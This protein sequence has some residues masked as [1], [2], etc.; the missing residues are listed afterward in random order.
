[1]CGLEADARIIFKLDD[2]NG[3]KVKV[4]F[5]QASYEDGK[6]EIESEVGEEN[7]S[8]IEAAKSLYDYS[9][10]QSVLKGFEYLSDARVEMYSKHKADLQ[11]L[12][13]VYKANL[14]QEKYDVMFRSS[15]KGTYSAYCNSLNST[16]SLAEEKKYRRNMKERGR[17]E[18]Y[19]KIEKDLKEIKG[20]EVEYILKE[21]E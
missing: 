14:S 2:G 10:L 19:K 1:M 5:Q 15:E 12:K 4:A 16:D 17:A 11:L 18:L 20:S 13:K 7:Y 6:E 3:E 8:I 21:I 9:Q